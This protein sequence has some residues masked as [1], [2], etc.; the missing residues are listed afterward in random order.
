MPDHIRGLVRTSV[1]AVISV[2]LAYGP[3]AQLLE[4]VQVTL[5]AEQVTVFLVPLVMALYWAAGS[6]LQRSS[7]VQSEPVL[8][9]IVGLAMGGRAAPNYSDEFTVVLDDGTE[10]SVADYVRDTFGQ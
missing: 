7:F 8:E 6:R 9:A 2:L 3:V 10:V 4:L 5:S 1:Q